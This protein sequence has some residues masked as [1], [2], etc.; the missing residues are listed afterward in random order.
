MAVIEKFLG[1]QVDIPEA[2]NYDLKQGLWARREDNTVV[3]GISQPAL[4]LS[5]GL[6]DLEWLVGDGSTVDAGES[7][8]FAITGKIIYIDAPIV[9]KIRLNPEVKENPGEI[10]ADPY[11]RGWLFSIEPDRHVDIAFNSLGTAAHYLESLQNS[12]G[13]KNPEG[14]KGG[15]SGICKSVYT[16]IGR[17][18]IERGEPS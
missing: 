2:L 11:G 9:G 12:E 3:F 7:V 14:I 6:K 15:V 10:T 17:Q 1:Q 8:V 5:A 16:G 18:N 4:V 13:F